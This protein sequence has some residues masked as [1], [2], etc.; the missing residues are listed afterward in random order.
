MIVTT[1][2]A[3]LQFCQVSQ[4]FGIDLFFPNMIGNYL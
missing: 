2:T 4:I 1:F 3:I